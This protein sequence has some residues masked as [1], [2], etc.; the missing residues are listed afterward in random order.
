MFNSDHIGLYEGLCERNKKEN[1]DSI[2]AL[3][4]QQTDYS[5]LA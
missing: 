4:P 1:R 2:M 5:R 3:N